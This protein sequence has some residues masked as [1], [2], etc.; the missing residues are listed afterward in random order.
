LSEVQGIPDE[1]AFPS[2]FMNYQSVYTLSPHPGATGTWDFNAQMIPHPIGFM[3]GVKG[4]SVDSTK[5]EF[6]NNQIDGASHAQKYVEFTN[7]FSRWRLAYMGVTVYQ[8]GPD[9]ANQGTI[10][11]CQTPVKP[12]VGNVY[13]YCQPNSDTGLVLDD[14]ANVHTMGFQEADF[15]DFNTTQTMPNAYFNNSKY[16]AYVPLKLSRTHQEWKSLSDSVYVN[17]VSG[18]GN[19]VDHYDPHLQI[20]AATANPDWGTGGSY[21][22]ISLRPATKVDATTPGVGHVVGDQTSPICNDFWANISAQNLS[23]QTSYSFFVRA[24]YECQCLPGTQLTP[25]QKLSPP[26]DPQA[27]AEYFAIARELK[28]AYPADYNDLGKILDVIRDAVS[29]VGDVF[30][31]IPHPVFQGLGMAAKG[32]T[33]LYDSVKRS[34]GGKNKSEASAA[35]IQRARTAL[36]VKPAKRRASVKGVKFVNRR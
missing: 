11:V 18:D 14:W 24:G 22:F 21:P 9:L 34:V 29:T 5:F 31:S 27:V 17:P 26:Y 32:G 1:S 3:Y 33:A 30:S 13:S 8:D 15:A 4:D 2:V 23:V 10:V 35:D 12:I 28:D 19:A 36:T 25:H 20:P 6:M 16:G 7:T